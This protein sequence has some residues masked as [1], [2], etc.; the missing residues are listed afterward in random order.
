MISAVQCQNRN[1]NSCSGNTLPI[2]QETFIIQQSCLQIR[3]RTV[4]YLITFGDVWCLF[5][6]LSFS[7]GEGYLLRNGGIL[8]MICRLVYGRPNVPFCWTDAKEKGQQRALLLLYLSNLTVNCLVQ[9]RFGKCT[10]W[11]LT[12]TPLKQILWGMDT[13]VIFLQNFDQCKILLQL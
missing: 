9:I 5:P 13:N 2:N 6:E 10:S 3:K 11:V 7:I 8:G 1:P 12:G 4:S